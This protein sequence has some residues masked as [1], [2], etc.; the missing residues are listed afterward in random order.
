MVSD[1]PVT[2]TD[3]L[4][5]TVALVPVSHSGDNADWWVAANVSGTSTI[6]GWYYF[7]L[8]AFGFMPVGDSAFNLLVT[9]QGLLSNL[10]TFEILD[11]P[12]SGLP[13]GTYT[14]YFAVDLNMNGLLDVFELF[15]DGVVVNI[16]P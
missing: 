8:S 4:S 2:P 14:F 5:V 13:S 7:D 10:P 9:H 15:F 12:V 1:G 16:T 6:D 3:N 11:I